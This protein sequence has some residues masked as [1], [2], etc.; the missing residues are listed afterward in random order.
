[1]PRPD[2]RP[3]SSVWSRLSRGWHRPGAEALHPTA[4][5]APPWAK[6]KPRALIGRGPNQITSRPLSAFGLWPLQT[7]SWRVS[8]KQS[9]QVAGTEVSNRGQRPTLAIL[10]S[11]Q[12][13]RGFRH[14]R[15]N[16]HSAFANTRFSHLRI[17]AGTATMINIAARPRKTETDEAK[18]ARASPKE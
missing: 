6:Q 15:A 4:W 11:N 3:G 8:A 10:P 5:Y 1:M 18:F 16:P 2:H 9:M 7:R 17:S 14:I 13:G 12:N